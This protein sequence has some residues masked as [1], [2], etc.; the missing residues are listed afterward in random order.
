MKFLLTLALLIALFVFNIEATASTHFTK[1]LTLT[2]RGETR[3]CPTNTELCIFA[4]GKICYDPVEGSCCE[5]GSGFCSGGFVCGYGIAINYCCEPGRTMDECVQ[6]KSV[7]TATAT[8]I[9]PTP[10]PSP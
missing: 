8:D 10:V 7:G 1:K 9:P 6:A 4:N 3:R 2:P 5:D